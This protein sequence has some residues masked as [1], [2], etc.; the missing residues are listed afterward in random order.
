M[1]RSVETLRTTGATCHIF[2]SL[3][4]LVD[5]RGKIEFTVDSADVQQERSALVEICEHHVSVPWQSPSVLH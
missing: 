5:K 1:T 3:A 4:A 2:Y